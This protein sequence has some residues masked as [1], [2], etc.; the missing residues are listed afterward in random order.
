[1]IC[2]RPTASADFIYRVVVSCTKNFSRPLRC[3]TMKI[4]K[5]TPML[6]TENLKQTID[7]YTQLLGFTC[8]HCFPDEENPQWTSLMKDGVEL[9]FTTR[10][11]HS[12]V[13]KATMTGSFYFNSENV[14][15]VWDQL[16][17]KVTIEYP[18]ETFHYG[19]REFAIRDRN[20]YLLQFGQEIS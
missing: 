3:I 9:M 5:M 19:M 8:Q 10:N 13:E 11:A 12:L 6:E 4:L 17:D 2:R 16:K 7:F 1:L 15:E 14:D 18:I 20:G